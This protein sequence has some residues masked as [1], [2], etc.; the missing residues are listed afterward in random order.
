MRE[1]V[2]LS[3]IRVHG[4]GMREAVP[5]ST[6]QLLGLGI[7]NDLAGGVAARQGT[8][9]ARRRVVQFAAVQISQK[10]IRVPIYR[11]PDRITPV[12]SPTMVNFVDFPDFPE[13]CQWTNNTVLGT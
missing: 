13:P 11:Y 7:V 4:I 1:A 9:D 6:V 12:D 8:Y 10:L 2:L 5:L 3:T